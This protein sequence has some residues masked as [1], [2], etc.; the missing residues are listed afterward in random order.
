ML[1]DH[2]LISKAKEKIGD[3]NAELIAELLHI[4]Q[5]DADKQ[6]GL[7]PFHAEDTPSFIYNPKTYSFHCFGCGINADLIDAYVK[8]GFT[9]I[10]AVQ[11]L[12]EHA[13]IKYA[14]G[15]L[16][17][18][19]QQEYRYPHD[20]EDDDKSKVYEYLKKRKISPATVDYAG[21]RQD[22]HGNIVFRFFDTNDVL[23]MVK[24]RPARKVEHGENKMWCQ[25]NADT[26][27]LLFNMNRV[28]TDSPLMICEGEIDC[29][30]AIEAGW[31]NAVS[32][33]LGAKNTQWIQHNWDWLQQFSTIILCG[34]NDE[35]G[36]QMI[37]DVSYRLGSWRTKI[38]DVPE[39]FTKL[40]GSTVAVKDLNEVLYYYGKEKVLDILVHAKDSPVE[41]VIDFADI[42]DIDLDEI[43]GIYTGIKQFDVE[44]LRLFYGTFNILTGVNGC[45]DC[46]TEYFNGEQWKK[47]SDYSSGEKVLQY[48]H[49][50]TAKLVIPEVYHKYPADWF[51]HLHSDYGVEQCVSPEHNLV[52]LTSKGH[53]QKKN[54]QEWIAVHE[55]TA[56]GFSGKFITTFNY[57]GNGIGLTDDEIRLMCAVICDGHFPRD[58]NRCRI[59]I[60][61]RQKQLR[62]RTL[63]E[64]AG[65]AY[66]VHHYNQNDLAF[67]TFI[68]DAPIRTKVF[69]AD[70]YQCSKQQLA[71]ISDEILHW[72]GHISE[73]RS[74]F[75]TCEKEN[76]DFVQFVFSACGF[77]SVVSS[78]N[79]IGKRHSN[80]RYAYKSIEYTVSK[81]TSI[82]PSLVNTKEKINI[83]LVKAKDG[84]KY[85]FT[86]PSGMLVLRRNGRINI[87]GNSGKSSFLSQLVCQC[88]EQGRDAWM[89][90]KELP[91]YMAKNWIN[92]ILAGARNVN[93]F[94]SER[95]AVYYKVKNEAKQ[96]IDAFY[97]GRLY[98]YKD[99]W[100][101]TIE[102][103]E[104][105]MEDSAR[106]FGSR[107]FII[108][109][110]TA[111]NLHA[112]D[113]SKWEKQVDFINY[114]I[115]FAQKYNVVVILVIHPKKIETMRR[116]T[117]FDVAGLGSIVD[118]AHRT[119]SLYRVT[120]QDKEGIKKK[121]GTGYYKEPIQYDV[122]LDVLKDRL[123]GRENLSIGLFYDKASRRF[124]TNPEEYDIQYSWDKNKYKDAL[125]YPHEDDT[126]EV[127]GE[128]KNKA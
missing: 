40:D 65:V 41:S 82:H 69:G 49:D 126:K 26:A 96:R 29:L 102:D 81:T 107:L 57:S 89:Y 105:S 71:I 91:N 121:N 78:N 117:K 9:Y 19:T 37:K 47:I 32:V 24:Y 95:G 12:F 113:D 68:F 4:E 20:E 1:I 76:A 108:D 80:E 50:G 83:P 87:T 51:Y 64:K 59:N 44:M 114:L 10:G 17:V 85:C 111:I 125:P 8:S 5:Y 30:S 31:T 7:C 13:K 48:N 22:E 3:K 79:R 100:P 53:L 63:L 72:D 61:K 54:V 94:V 118:L 116:L 2:N 120:P 38:A 97:K 46:D 11:K 84:Y 25:K 60:K 6:R 86:V 98:I 128:V 112:S 55:N 14:F 15:Q 34:D 106:K 42:K 67:E 21:I 73:K 33:P 99:G 124:Y 74:S 58:N 35:P 93:A 127:F 27:P 56:H 75:S 90:S 77:R 36:R 43:D 103:I 109:N 52:Y 110:L 18:K 28:N 115:D 92:Y 16:G 62:L 119:F 70:W 23:T 122:L 88:L 104:Q 66:T 45:V 123:R 39:T 101:N